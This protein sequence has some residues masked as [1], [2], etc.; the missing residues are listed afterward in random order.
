MDKVLATVNNEIRK[1]YLRFVSLSKN[2]QDG[3]PGNNVFLRLRDMYQI[4]GEIDNLF[5][6]YEEHDI[7]LPM[8]EENS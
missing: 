7:Y 4:K 5:T 1:L 2:Q 8:P 3:K 6:A